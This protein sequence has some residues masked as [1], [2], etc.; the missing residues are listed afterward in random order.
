MAAHFARH[1][2]VAAADNEHALR[3]RMQH[4]RHMRDHFM[5]RPLIL[6]RRLENAVQDQHPP[7]LLRFGNLNLLKRRRFLEKNFI[8][9]QRQPDMGRRP[10]R[11]DVCTALGTHF[12]SSAEISI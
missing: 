2:A 1:A 7:V 5:I 3:P 9:G 4:E 12:V 8:D 11:Q 6:H 10:F